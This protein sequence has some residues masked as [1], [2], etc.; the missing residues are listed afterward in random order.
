MGDDIKLS[1]WQ[2]EVKTNQ[3]QNAIPTYTCYSVTKLD[4][5]DNVK[6]IILWTGEIPVLQIQTFVFPISVNG[7]VTE[8]FLVLHLDA[9]PEV[10]GSE[11]HLP[12]RR[13][14]V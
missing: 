9:G 2:P 12:R 3:W 5:T 4:E 13:H 11:I 7:E 10:S 8:D 14:N 6:T 1:C